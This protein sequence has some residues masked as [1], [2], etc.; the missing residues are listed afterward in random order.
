MNKMIAAAAIASCGVSCIGTASAQNSVTVYGIVDAAID[1]N[2]NVDAEGRSRVW[3]PSLGG[4]M[5]PSRLG[6][7][8]TEDLG[9]GLKAIFLLEN[10]FYID[11][12]S[13]GQNRLFGRQAWV[14]LSGNWGQLTFGRNYNMIYNS[15]L[16]V[17]IVGPSNY[18]L[19]AIDP[20]IPNGRSDNSIAYKGTFQGFTV[21]ATYSLGRDVSNAGGPSGSNCAGESAVDAQACREWSAMLRYD[22]GNWGVASAYDHIR[23][24]AGAAGG[25]TRSDLS[26]RRANV[27]GYVK[28][29]KLKLAG[30]VL[31]RK[32]EGATTPPRSN[33]YYLGAAYRLT[34]A[35]MV[36]G[37]LARL[38]YKHSGNDTNAM[39]VRAMYD[40]SKR[41]TV[42]IAAGRMDNHGTAAIPLSAGGTVGVG[43]AQNG[44]IAGIKH[45]F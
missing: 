27:A 3:M 21:G 2:T 33:L 35:L 45:S 31:M 42:Y 32:N 6:F 43:M 24:G 12:G 28:F 22:G 41:T 10:G 16:E 1:Y 37:H 36:D 14:G 18:G 40:F 44:V 4:G 13:N 25:L 9:G 19:G 23:G 8:G 30:G 38:D 15:M 34:P 29:G 17:D 5:F 11:S 7:K 20:A 39:L 26:D